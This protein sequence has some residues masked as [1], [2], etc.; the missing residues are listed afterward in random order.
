MDNSLKLAIA[1]HLRISVS[2]SCVLIPSWE[3]RGHQHHVRIWSAVALSMI[4]YHAN[5][6]WLGLPMKDYHLGKA[7]G[8][9]Q[10]LWSYTPMKINNF[11]RGREKMTK[12]NQQSWV[13]IYSFSW[14]GHFFWIAPNPLSLL[15]KTCMHFPPQ[16]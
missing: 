6:H 9:W 12:I 10:H 15:N 1:S 4:K 14:E 13:Y 11:K 5:T 7:P 8:G 3:V 2:D 16:K